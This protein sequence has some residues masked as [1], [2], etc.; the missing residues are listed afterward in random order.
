MEA[1]LEQPLALEADDEKTAS[2]IHALLQSRLALLLGQAY[3]DQFTV[4][5][6]LALEFASG[7]TRPDLCIFPKLPSTGPTTKSWC[8][9]RP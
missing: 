5:T 3:R 8:G 1:E 2:L 9:K 4:L 6:E 7:K